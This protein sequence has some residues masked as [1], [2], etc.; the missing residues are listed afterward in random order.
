MELTISNSNGKCEYLKIIYTKLVKNIIN[1]NSLKNIFKIL[2]EFIFNLIN[3]KIPVEKLIISKD[4][5]NRDMY[6]N[7]FKRDY[8]HLKSKHSY[9]IIN[10]DDENITIDYMYY[11]ENIFMEPI[12]TLFS[13]VFI[14]DVGYTSKI[15]NKKI[16][17]STPIKMILEILKYENV[18]KLE[19]I[20]NIINDNIN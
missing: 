14:S 2:V 3:D 16:T 15:T 11:L 8:D 7:I 19:E 9:I 17:I 1:E 13:K 18:Y 6:V 10:E 4:T 12:D 5:F 20:L